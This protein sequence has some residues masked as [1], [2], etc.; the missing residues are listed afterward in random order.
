MNLNNESEK[1]MAST[2]IWNANDAT[3][4]PKTIDNCVKLSDS[5]VGSTENPAIYSEFRWADI[6]SGMTDIPTRCR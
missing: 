1:M 6:R 3:K 4:K 5:R 2:C